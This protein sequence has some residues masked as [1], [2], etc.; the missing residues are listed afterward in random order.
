MD[1]WIENRDN[2]YKPE[3][4]KRLMIDNP[5]SLHRSVMTQCAMH[6]TKTADEVRELLIQKYGNQ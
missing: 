4:M 1:A 6:G 2:E 3:S 5:G